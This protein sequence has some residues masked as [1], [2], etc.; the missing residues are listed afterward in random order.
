[1]QGQYYQLN[2]LY[3]NN[4]K[5]TS[6]LED[7][8]AKTSWDVN[9][10]DAIIAT[11]NANRHTNENMIRSI[12]EGDHGKVSE[13]I[14]YQSSEI[15]RLSDQL[16]NS[17]KLNGSIMA[18]RQQEKINKSATEKNIMTLFYKYKE[19][20]S[21]YKNELRS[22]DEEIARLEKL[23]ESLREQRNSLQV[24]ENAHGLTIKAVLADTNG[25]HKVMR[26][27]DLQNAIRKPFT[28]RK[29]KKLRRKKRRSLAIKTADLPKAT[30]NPLSP[31]A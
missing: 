7:A 23:S 19:A 14:L 4:Q 5:R 9:P 30:E 12:K 1:M 28:G 27:S 8:L 13:H 17:K 15:S 10:M 11:I 29:A 26:A 24:R 6:H 20:T 18:L 2:E 16:D 25:F 31:A 22:K 3:K 21:K